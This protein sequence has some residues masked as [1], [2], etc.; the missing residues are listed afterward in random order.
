[1]TSSAERHLP[2]QIDSN[3]DGKLS[4]SEVQAGVASLDLALLTRDEARPFGCVGCIQS[5]FVLDSLYMC[6]MTYLYYYSFYTKS[7]RKYSLK[8]PILRNSPRD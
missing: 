3:A 4:L 7:F 5:S 2:R 8:F 6:T 1:M